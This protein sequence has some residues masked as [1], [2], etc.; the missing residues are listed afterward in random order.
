MI[1]MQPAQE[2]RCVEQINR[3]AEHVVSRGHQLPPVRSTPSRRIASMIDSPLAT[4]SSQSAGVN[5]RRFTGRHDT[6]CSFS[7]YERIQSSVADSAGATTQRSTSDPPLSEP[8]ASCLLYT[9]DAA[10]DLTRVDLGGRR[11]IK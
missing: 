7:T 2:L 4:A 10:D 11:I 8:R 3:L 9:S 5:R 6:T 1:L